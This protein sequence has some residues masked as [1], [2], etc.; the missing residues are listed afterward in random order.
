MTYS[1]ETST[2][3]ANP[4][5]GSWFIIHKPLSPNECVYHG[6]ILDFFDGFYFCQ[7]YDQSEVSKKTYQK[8]IPIS[9]LMNSY[10]FNS[11]LGLKLYYN[12]LTSS[13]P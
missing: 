2:S 12:N 7:I 11:Q 10:I 8:L 9:D 6:Q 5:V 4:L 13:P 3:T 1:Y